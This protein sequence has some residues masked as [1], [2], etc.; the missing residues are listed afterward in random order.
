MKMKKMKNRQNV[1]FLKLL[2]GQ[3]PKNYTYVDFTK[4]ARHFNQMVLPPH[5]TSPSA[6][7]TGGGRGGQSNDFLVDVVT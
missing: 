1:K 7:S 2:G 6:T 3:L 5:I 4:S